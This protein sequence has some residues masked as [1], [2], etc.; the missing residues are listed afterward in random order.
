MNRNYLEGAIDTHVH[1]APDVRERKMSDLDLVDAAVSRSVR[2]IVIKSHH[3]PTVG[4]A[5]I[6]NEYCRRIYGDMTGFQMFGG[7]TLNQF[8]GGL[9]PWAVETALKMG[10][11]IVWLPTVHSEQQTKREN[12]EGAV[13]CVRDGNVVPELVSIMKLVKEHDA[14]LATAHLSPYDIFTIVEKAKN[15]GL[16]KIVINHPESN[17]V[18]LRLEE[19]KRLALDYGAKLERCYAQPIG[20]GKYKS[21]LED[22]VLA[23]NEIGSEHLIIATDA[24]QTQNPYWYESFG[25]SIRYM[26]EHGASEEDLDAM[27][28]RNPAYILGI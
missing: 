17:L 14:A 18:G 21:N 20:G 7:I 4:R 3:V 6:A 12:K 23:M 13:I 22:N 10:G 8:V 28:K 19:Q 9:N 15:L 5:A 24:G 25:E 2:A 11:K 26:A 1:S 27:V 16:E